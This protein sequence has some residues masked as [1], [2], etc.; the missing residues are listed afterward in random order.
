MCFLTYP[1]AVEAVNLR[2]V[3]RMDCLLPASVKTDRGE[4]KAVIVDISLGG[5]RILP[6][7]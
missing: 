3:Q 1:S 7:Q 6:R 4:H 5:C 2:K